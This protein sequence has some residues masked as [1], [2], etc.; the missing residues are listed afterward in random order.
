MTFL[1]DLSEFPFQM[2]ITG[3]G[4]KY[5]E[6]TNN[7][8]N[9]KSERILFYNFYF[10][11]KYKRNATKAIRNTQIGCLTVMIVCPLIDR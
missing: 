11:K 7:N 2:K 9:E 4:K 10:Q 3:F 6:K 1:F 5:M 8:E